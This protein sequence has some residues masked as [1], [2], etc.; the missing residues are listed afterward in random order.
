MTSAFSPAE[1]VRLAA[2]ADRAMVA[3][4]E[5]KASAHV[6]PITAASR[7]RPRVASP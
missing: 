3:A 2:D 4:S 5:V 7:G 6:V 1:C